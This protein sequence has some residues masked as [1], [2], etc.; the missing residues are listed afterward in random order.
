[1]IADLRMRTARGLRRALVFLGG[2]AILACAL[3]CMR[4]RSPPTNEPL[5]QTYADPN[6]LVTVRYPA[7]FAASVTGRNVIQVARNMPGGHSEAVFVAAIETPISTDPVEFNR[8]MS[9][10]TAR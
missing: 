10:A 7:S 9:L 8:V 2:G 3:A 6:R 1:M 5:T 4:R